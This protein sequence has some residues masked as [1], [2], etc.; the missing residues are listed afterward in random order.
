MEVLSFKL[1]RVDLEVKSVWVMSHSR[2]CLRQPTWGKSQ[3]VVCRGITSMARA[4]AMDA[5]SPLSVAA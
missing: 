3:T 1:C 4:M 5:V 2:I